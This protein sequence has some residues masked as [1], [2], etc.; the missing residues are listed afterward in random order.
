MVLRPEHYARQSRNGF[1]T[2]YSSASATT[3]RQC[4]W[5]LKI[6]DTRAIQN[7]HYQVYLAWFTSLY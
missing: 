4:S 5:Y 1:Y 6:R 3:V 2:V 7:L